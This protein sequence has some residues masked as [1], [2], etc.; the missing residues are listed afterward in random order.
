MRAYPE[1][2]TAKTERFDTIRHYLTQNVTTESQSLAETHQPR[3][4][5][6][7]LISKPPQVA[8]GTRSAYNLM[9]VRHARQADGPDKTGCGT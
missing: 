1:P 5:R 4:G 9:H 7:N 2:Q 6:P 8:L 3:D